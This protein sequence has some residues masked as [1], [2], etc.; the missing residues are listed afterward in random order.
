[1]TLVLRS[2]TRAIRANATVRAVYRYGVRTVGRRFTRFAF[3]SVLALAASEATLELCLIAHVW[4]TVAG[5]TGWF[6]GALVS[7]VLSRW[8]WERRGRPHL[9]KETLPFWLISAGTVIVLSAATSLGQHLALWWRLPP[10]ERLAFV[11]FVYL[12]ANALTFLTRF[13]IFHYFLFADRGSEEP[14]EPSADPASGPDVA[15]G[16]ADS[17][18]GPAGSP[19]AAAPAAS[20]S[21][22]GAGPVP[23]GGSDAFSPA[24][25]R[26]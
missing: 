3:G 11:G 20:P 2:V 21:P 15:P 13:L 18:R 6:A 14:G 24:P 23:A 8:A 22:D 7:Y 17:A 25:G 1:M 10:V 5:A 9:I 19:S 12:A 4:P 26:G 16:P